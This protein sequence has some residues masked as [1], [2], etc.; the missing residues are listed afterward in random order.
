MKRETLGFLRLVS[1]PSIEVTM[2]AKNGAN[3]NLN[4]LYLLGQ[5]CC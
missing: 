5:R 3:L 1:K 2:N 4:A